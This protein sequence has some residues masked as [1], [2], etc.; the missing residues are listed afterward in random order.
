[1]SGL[2]PTTFSA[3]V[4]PQVCSVLLARERREG[5]AEWDPEVYSRTGMM[6]MAMPFFSCSLFLSCVPLSTGE[7]SSSHPWPAALPKRPGRSSIPETWNWT[8]SFSYFLLSQDVFSPFCDHGCARE[9][10]P[11]RLNTPQHRLGTLFWAA[12]R[13]GWDKLRSLDHIVK[14][15]FFNIYLRVLQKPAVFTGSQDSWGWMA[16]QMLSHPTPLAQAVSAGAGCPG[17]HPIVF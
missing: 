8:T 15:S 6:H 14:P 16:L 3:A 1:M 11:E 4:L 10:A 2:L 13:T 12:A 5:L 9:E 17:P 7:D